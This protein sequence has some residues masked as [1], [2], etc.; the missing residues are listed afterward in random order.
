MEVVSW[1]Q[2]VQGNSEEDGDGDL[3]GTEEGKSGVEEKKEMGR[4]WRGGG[5]RKEGR[6]GACAGA[7]GRAGAATLL[8][9]SST[10][11]RPPRDF[12]VRSRKEGAGLVGCQAVWVVGG[13]C[14]HASP[15]GLCWFSFSFVSFFL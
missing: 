13:L 9:A 5:E 10:G 7:V 1:L 2:K 3:R 8:L 14:E 6:S 12:L 4:A 15:H 11:S